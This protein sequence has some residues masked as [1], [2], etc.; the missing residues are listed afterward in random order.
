MFLIIEAFCY[1]LLAAE[2]MRFFIYLSNP[3]T[4]WWKVHAERKWLW[5][6]IIWCL[7]DENPDATVRFIF[8]LFLVS[9]VT[10]HKIYF[11][12]SI[13]ATPSNYG[14]AID[15]RQSPSPLRETVYLNLEAFMQGSSYS[16][17]VFNPVMSNVSHT[18]RCFK[19]SKWR[20]KQGK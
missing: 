4:A 9:N 1:N 15:H 13:S 12:Y 8:Y 20:F 17:D 7:A 14:Y 6:P 18:T 5:Q 3:R 2:I 16:R 11:Y 19:T 10:N